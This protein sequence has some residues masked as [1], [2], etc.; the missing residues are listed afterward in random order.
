MARKSFKTVPEMFLDRVAETPDGAAFLYAAG[1]EWK[2]L[3]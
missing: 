2:T 3:S 1:A